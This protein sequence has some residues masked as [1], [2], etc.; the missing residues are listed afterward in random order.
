M[1]EFVVLHMIPLA[2]L[3]SSAIE[4]LFMSFFLE[5]RRL[6]RFGVTLIYR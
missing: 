6:S 4:H 1:R 3:E 5:N 2:L